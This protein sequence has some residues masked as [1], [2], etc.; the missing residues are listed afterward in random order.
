MAEVAE[1]IGRSPCAGRAQLGAPAA[2]RDH[3]ARRREDR[4]QLRDNLGCLDFTLYAEQLQR[5]SDASRIEL[6]FP[7]DFLVGA[8]DVVFG[9]TFGVI[10][11]H[12]S[13][14]VK[15]AAVSGRWSVASGRWLVVSSFRGWG[16]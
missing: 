5:L 10:D 9:G 12:R 6:G 15:A 3:P 16:R 4:A 14:G 11:N 8:R 13:L 1:E 7:H 2:G